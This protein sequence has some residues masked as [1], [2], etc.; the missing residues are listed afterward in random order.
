MTEQ[1]K[2]EICEASGLSTEQMNT[3]MGTP[4]T[5]HEM[6]DKL[7]LYFEE[8][9]AV[10]EH[11]GERRFQIQNVNFDSL[12]EVLSIY[13]NDLEYTH[14]MAIDEFHDIFYEEEHRK[15]FS[16]FAITKEEITETWNRVKPMTAKEALTRYPN[17]EQRMIALRYIGAEGMIKELNAELLDEKTIT[18][19]QE[20]TVFLGEGQ[21][22]HK[23]H[24]DASLWTKRIKEYDDTY[25][26]YRIHTDEIN[27]EDSGRANIEFEYI[28]I[29]GMKDTSTDREYYIF[30]DPEV[31]EEEKDAI[32]A[33]ASTLRVV[34]EEGNLSSPLSKEDYFALRSET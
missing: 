24:K 26:L 23:K 12:E 3:L 1:K 21:P 4:N 28:Y 33:I 34:D 2:K 18:K 16:P 30:V 31:V 5:V 22:D 20:E 19:K 29:C 7:F 6:N 8:L 10:I 17:M 13:K 15:M 27:S 11:N 32:K 9:E 14:D 25:K